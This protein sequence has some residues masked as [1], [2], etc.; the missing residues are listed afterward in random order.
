M[1]VAVEGLLYSS[2]SL[3]SWYVHT[4]DSGKVIVL[5]WKSLGHEAVRMTNWQVLQFSGNGSFDHKTDTREA[6]LVLVLPRQEED[7]ASRVLRGGALFRKVY[8][9][10]SSNID[11]QPSS[12]PGHEC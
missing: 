9:A 10:E 3:Q 2:F 4:E 6:A 7:I 5:D 11:V 8:F 1:Q 12:F